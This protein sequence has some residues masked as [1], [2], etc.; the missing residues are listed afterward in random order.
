MSINVKSMQVN[1]EIRDPQIRLVG[2]DGAQLGL[3][4]A[5]D[6][7]KLAIQQ[8][9]DLVKIAPSATPPVCKLMD[10]SKYC[11]EQSKKEKELRK[12]Q[13]IVSV[14]EVQLTL[15]IEDHDLNTKLNHALR[16]L[17]GGDKVK[18]A[19]RFKSREI[20]HP[21]WG[22]EMMARFF[23]GCKEVSVIEKPAKLDGRNMIMILAPK[24]VKPAE[25]A[26]TIRSDSAAENASEKQ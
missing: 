2:E 9:L 6:A 1:E 19:L 22:T 18:V 10:Y 12:N 21:E 23:D 25:A 5:K 4:T 13:K 17:G 11:F 8:G 20:N 7:Q 26:K 15:K 24:A 16:F 14:K 3:Y